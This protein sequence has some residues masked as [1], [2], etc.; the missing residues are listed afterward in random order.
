[1]KIE[2]KYDIGHTYWVARVYKKYKKNNLIL[3]GQ[4]YT[5]E[6]TYFEPVAKKKYIYGVHIYTRMVNEEPETNIVYKVADYAKKDDPSYMT[7]EFTKSNYERMFPSEE[8][9]MEYARSYKDNYTG[10]L[11][12]VSPIEE[13]EI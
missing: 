9:A 4:V 1:M 13:W 11:Y 6:T 3:N 8:A 7:Y 2:T 5:N 12:N 10:E